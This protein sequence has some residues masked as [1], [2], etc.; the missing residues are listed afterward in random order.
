MHPGGY[1]VI[2]LCKGREVDRFIYGMYSVELYPELAPF[3][4]SVNSIKLAGFPIAKI[5]TPPTYEGIELEVNDGTI[6]FMKCI[7]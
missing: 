2:E 4:H 5:V 1:K 7:S 6:K 3:S